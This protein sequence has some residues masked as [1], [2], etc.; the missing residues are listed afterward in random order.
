MLRD[1]APTTVDRA[2]CG[3]RRTGI[4]EI[5][6]QFAQRSANTGSMADLDG[7]DEAL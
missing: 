5:T 1:A 3:K 6:R 7:L 4:Q 2:G